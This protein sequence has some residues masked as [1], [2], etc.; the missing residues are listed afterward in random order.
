M[1]WFLVLVS[2]A[3]ALLIGEMVLSS[4]VRKRRQKMQPSMPSTEGPYRDSPPLPPAQAFDSYALQWARYRN[5]E[6]ASSRVTWITIIP[7]AVVLQYIFGG[8][9]SGG[10][11][12]V[13]F[14]AIAVPAWVIVRHRFTR[15]PCPRCKKPFVSLQTNEGGFCSHCRL[16]RD[17]PFDPDATEIASTKVR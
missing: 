2:I 3:V 16:R 6:M 15:F 17:S 7:V 5:L 11:V 8:G 10:V 12:A 1:G 14:M 4:V 9:D 13:V